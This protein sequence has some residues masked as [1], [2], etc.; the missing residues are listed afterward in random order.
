MA[1][2]RIDEPSIYINAR[3]KEFL[4]A[5]GRSTSPYVISNGHA[6]GKFVELGFEYFCSIAGDASIL[7]RDLGW[8]QIKSTGYVQKES[9]ADA[10][11]YAEAVVAILQKE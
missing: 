2:I 11:A 10:L 4:V 9:K 8:T 1:F 3:T 6:L 7:V 5:Q